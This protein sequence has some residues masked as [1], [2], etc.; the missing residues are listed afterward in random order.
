MISVLFLCSS[1]CL[2][3]KYSRRYREHIQT[4]NTCL[5]D[6]GRSNSWNHS[7]RI[8]RQFIRWNKVTRWIFQHWQRCD[9]LF[10]YGNSKKKLTGQKCFY[11][12]VFKMSNFKDLTQCTSQWREESLIMSM[13]TEVVTV[14]SNAPKGFVECLFQRPASV[15][16][17]QSARLGAQTCRVRTSL[18]PTSFSFRQKN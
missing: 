11:F 3:K 2:L 12:R 14:S 17:R 5:H 16:E 8:V 18:A 10:I 6:S 7:T 1:Y 13:V 9:F 4:V 15:S